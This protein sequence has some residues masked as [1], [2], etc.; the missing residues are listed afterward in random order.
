MSKIPSASTVSVT[1]YLTSVGRS[2][3]LSYDKSGSPIRFTYDLGGNLID[4]F[5][6]T[7]F[8]VYDSDTN[9]KS[10]QS[11]NSGDLPALSGIKDKDLNNT[12][13]IITKNKNKLIK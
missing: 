13:N 9:Y 11:L 10:N 12:L 1:A 6:I 2:I 7:H 3:F 5:Q 4:N 8:S